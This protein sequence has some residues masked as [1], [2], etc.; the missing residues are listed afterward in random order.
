MS[1]YVVHYVHPDQARWLEHLE[2]HLHWIERRLGDGTL[3]AS[4]PLQDVPEL[5]AL[6]LF[7]ARDRQHVDRLIADDP[8]VA[9]GLLTELT[10]TRWDPGFGG[11]RHHAGP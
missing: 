6:L 2:S 11:L 4:G 5:S 8:F 3:V 10:I 1:L 7:K 9:E